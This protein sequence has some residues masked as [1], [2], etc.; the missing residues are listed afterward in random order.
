LNWPA[1]TLQQADEVTGPYSD[2]ST[3]L[4]L[5]IPANAAKKFYRVK[6]Q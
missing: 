2:L 1:G 5:T 3:A 4:T 6:F